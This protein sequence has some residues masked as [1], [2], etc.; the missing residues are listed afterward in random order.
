M[1]SKYF[2]VTVKP[3][4]KASKQH[5]GAFSA[6]DVLFDWTPFQIPRGSARLLNT[7]VTVRGVDGADQGAKDI[8]LFFAKSID[9]NAPSTLGDSNDPVDSSGWQNNLIGYQMLDHS[10]NSTGSSDDLVY[11]TTLTSGSRGGG[12]DVVLTGELDSG[13][14]VGYDTVYVACLTQGAHNFS[15]TVIA[16]GGT[17][18]D[19][20][21]AVVETDK[22]SNDDPDAELIFVPGDVLATT[23]GT[24]DRTLGT[25]KSIAAFGS[26]KQDITFEAAIEATIADNEEIYNLNPVVLK[27]SF[28]R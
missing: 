19:G 18:A 6:G 9:G 4:V 11:I 12:P 10:S 1:A 25:V 26:S 20:S 3:T 28:E 13:D 16:R 17:T 8:E 23:N 24:D 2:D 5:A 7:F 27:F 15:T 21:V 14:N 22:G